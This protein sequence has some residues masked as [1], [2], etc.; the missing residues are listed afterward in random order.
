MKY[1]AGDT[2]LVPAKIEQIETY[3]DET[4]VFLSSDIWDGFGEAEEK[5]LVPYEKPQKSSKIR[6]KAE[7][8]GENRQKAEGKTS[9]RQQDTKRQ[10]E[11]R[12]FKTANWQQEEPIPL[13]AYGR[14]VA[15]E[16]A[17]MQKLINK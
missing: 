6:D 17:E 16:L 14:V 3:G 2:V 7:E 1:K 13:S 15:K 9:E 5:D 11:A 4:T 10:Q 8:N 12:K